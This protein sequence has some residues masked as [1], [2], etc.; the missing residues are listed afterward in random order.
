MSR[1]LVT[2]IGLCY[3][4]APYLREALD[5][6]LAQTYPN[7][8]ILVA[9]DAST[10]D[11]AALLRDYVAQHPQIELTLHT[12]NQGN[13]R[14]FNELFRKVKGE[15]VV[16]FAL[17]DRF[18]PDRIERQVNLFETLGPEVSM[19]Y[20]N[21][22]R[23]SAD[24]SLLGTQFPEG[25]EQPTGDLFATLLGRHHLDP[26]ALLSRRTVFEGLGGYDESLAYEDFD[27]LVRAARDWQFAYLPDCL[28]ER[29]IVASGFAAQFVGERKRTLMESTLAV[30]RKAQGLV[31]TPEEK[32][33]LI[34]RTRAE[35]RF[36][37]RVKLPE[38]MCQYWALLGE[39]GAR[40]F[41]EKLLMGAARLGLFLYP[42]RRA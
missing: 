36:A 29:R 33:A 4:Q 13:R 2:V 6:V 21:V 12:E 41:K 11:S 3:N 16:D 19:I 31:K 35:L 39:L 37:Y 34:G 20:T 25:S 9:D 26:C 27:F 24:G 30:L 14:T 5:S 15:Y 17:D 22:R 42:A 10:D 28:T 7:L 8:Q 40:P 1:P 32:A 23:I 18:A 38:M